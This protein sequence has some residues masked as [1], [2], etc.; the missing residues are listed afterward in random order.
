ML[1]RNSANLSIT[2]STSSEEVSAR[3]E[4]ALDY[5]DKRN[6]K[7]LVNSQNDDPRMFRSV[8]SEATTLSST[9]EPAKDNRDDLQGL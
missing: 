3:Q 5:Q 4:K 1:A 6:A 9:A 2:R 7:D 8:S